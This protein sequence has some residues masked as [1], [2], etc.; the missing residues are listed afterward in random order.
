MFN[1]SDHLQELRAL[2]IGLV[3]LLATTILGLVWISIGLYHCLT[4]YLGSTWGPIVLGLIFFVPMLIFAVVKAFSGNTQ[5]SQQQATL[6]G[7]ADVSALNITKV[8]ES[9]SG[10]SP[11]FVAAVAIIAG[12]LAARFPALLTMF[13]QILTAYAEEVKAR[14]T[15]NAT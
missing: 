14:A 12:V 6:N 15:K 13:M 11:F 5:H 2:I 1:F 9:L 4:G 7:Y 10:H 8:I 3:L